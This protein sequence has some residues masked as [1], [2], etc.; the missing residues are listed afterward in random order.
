MRVG[1][2]RAGTYLPWIGHR[3]IEGLTGRTKGGE[4]HGKDLFRGSPKLLRHPG[5]ALGAVAQR[6]KLEAVGRRSLHCA[7]LQY[8][9]DPESLAWTPSP[10]EEFAAEAALRGAPGGD[11]NSWTGQSVH[12]GARCLTR[13]TGVSGATW[14]R[15]QA[16]TPA[17]QDLY[18]SRCAGP[19]RFL[20]TPATTCLAA[21][22]TG[23]GFGAPG[24][25]GFAGEKN[26]AVRRASRGYGGPTCTADGRLLFFFLT[27]ARAVGA[28][29]GPPRRGQPA[30]S[31]DGSIRE[32]GGGN[33]VGAA[34]ELHPV[35]PATA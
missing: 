8:S 19:G 7:N 2:V 10:Q 14:A 12:P 11:L 34:A 25:S 4:G 31:A 26:T 17:A 21:G 30:R 13:W 24:R 29:W 6:S 9:I 20:T 5:Y 23:L 35:S 27:A 3:V 22:P 28:S 32:G 33:Q 15:G 18:Q 16:N 1:T